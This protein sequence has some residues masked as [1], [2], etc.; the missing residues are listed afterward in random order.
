MAASVDFWFEFASTY[1]YL[2]VSRVEQEALAAGVVVAW[3]PF[4]LGPIFKEQG[5]SDSPFNVYP[6]KGR[7]MWR[8]L[9]RLCD[10]YGIPFKRPTQFPRNGLLAARVTLAGGD[11]GWVP[12]FVKRA[13]RANF[14]EDRNIADAAVLSELLRDVGADPTTVVAEAGSDAVKAKLRANTEEAQRLGIF[15][16]PSF[17]ANGELFW[18]NDRLDDALAWAKRSA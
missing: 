14:A 5:W 16:A 3:R 4:L 6:V 7:Y 10:G 1:S 11:A 9:E 17:V 15:G 8:D 13:Y 18:G 12:G 2:A